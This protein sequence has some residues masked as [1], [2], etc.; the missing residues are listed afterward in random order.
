MYLC[1]LT[2]FSSFGFRSMVIMVGV[3][4]ARDRCWHASPLWMSPVHVRDGNEIF[5]PSH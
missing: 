3:V 2:L 1:L 5:L 4:A